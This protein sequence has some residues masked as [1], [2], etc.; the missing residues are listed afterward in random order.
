MNEAFLNAVAENHIRYDGKIVVLK[1]GGEIWDNPAKRHRVL[2]HIHTLQ[3]FGARVIVVNGGGKQITEEYARR[4]LTPVFENGERMCDKEGL[5]AAMDALRQV[6]N[7]IAAEY[8]ELTRGSNRGFR[9]FPVN[10]FDMRLVEAN[11]KGPGLYTGDVARVN[12][13]WLLNM[14]NGSPEQIFIVNS[15]CSDANR[16]GGFLNVNADF[17]ASAIAGSVRAERF[18]MGTTAPGIVDTSIDLVEYLRSLKKHEGRS[19]ERLQAIAD[20]IK[21]TQK[22][23]RLLRNATDEQ[24]EYLI[25][26]GVINGGMIPKTRA[27]LDA[28]ARGVLGSVILDS[29]SLLQE[30]FTKKGAGTLIVRKET[31]LFTPGVKL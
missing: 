17:V 19:E 23:P 9:A 28:L 3:M 2:S 30:L 22:D 20:Q 10:G 24:I 21:F 14:M 18:L 13:D 11:S 26:Q 25:A 8:N 27:A 5:K 31:P 29:D 15:I 12:S 4:G 1:A 16:T 6:T 7:D